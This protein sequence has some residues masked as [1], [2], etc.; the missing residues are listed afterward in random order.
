M[1]LSLSLDLLLSLCK[2]LIFF[3]ELIDGI[4]GNGNVLFLSVT[5]GVAGVT[6]LAFVISAL[7]YSCNLDTS[8][9]KYERQRQPSKYPERPAGM[10]LNTRTHTHASNT[11]YL[12]PYSYYTHRKF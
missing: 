3:S 6:L 4:N 8:R 11:G 12:R 7:L 5:A 9:Q 2:L 10:Y 1:S